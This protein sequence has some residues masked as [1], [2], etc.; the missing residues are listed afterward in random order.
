MSAASVPLALALG[1]ALGVRHAVDPD[2][3]AAVLALSRSDRRSGRVVASALAWGLGHSLT[4]LVCAL[5]VVMFGFAPPAGFEDAVTLAVGVTLIL[6]GILAIRRGLRD[7][8]GGSEE[9]GRSDRLRRRAFAVGG[10][11]GLAGS[12]AVALLALATIRD[13]R[14]A[15]AHLL[16]FCL[17]T[18]VGMAAIAYVLSRSLER[19]AGR[20]PWIGGLVSALAGGASMAV[21]LVLVGELIES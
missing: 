19:A 15:A 7:R 14:I 17:G 21:G 3:L 8:I 10:I 6:L 4:F 1:V 20:G 9:D 11:H 2:H 13:P 16:V 18:L 5:A 12:H